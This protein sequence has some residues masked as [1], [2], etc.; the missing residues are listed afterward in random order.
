MNRTDGTLPASSGRQMASFVIGFALIA[1]VSACSGDAARY[2]DVRGPL[3]GQEPPGDEPALFAPGIVSTLCTDRDLTMTPDCS[4]IAWAVT[5]PS[6]GGTFIVHTFRVGDRWTRPETVSFSGD[7][8]YTDAEPHLAPDGMTLWFAS[9]RPLPGAGEEPG[10]YNL[11]YAERTESGWGQPVNP[12]APLNTAE[13]G[14]FYPTLTTDGTVYFTRS[15]MAIPANHI[16][17]A[18]RLGDGWAEPELLP[19]EVNP[20]QAQYNAFVA[21]DESYIIVPTAT[22]PDAVGGAGAT[23]YYISFRSAQD[24]WTGPIH[25]GEAVNTADGREWAPYVSPD[26]QYFF[27]MTPRPT[28]FDTSGDE[29]LTYRDLL[30]R[31]LGPR[32]GDADVWW[33]SAAFIETLRPR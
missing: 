9:D 30:T 14:E 18:R 5:L 11:W 20:G 24:E 3:L 13:E 17:R 12:G 31:A 28:I 22:L 8:R 23:D 27:F 6:R 15:T 19:P 21:P 26:G 1:A 2:L 16:Y 29:S 10:D 7:P 25:M 32:S 4:E 33:V